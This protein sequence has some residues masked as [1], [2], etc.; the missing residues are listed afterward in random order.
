MLSVIIRREH[1]SGTTSEE[2]VTGTPRDIAIA[3]AMAQHSLL[4]GTLTSYK[5]EK[6]S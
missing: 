5:V 3:I 6:T 4:Y 2:T 1:A